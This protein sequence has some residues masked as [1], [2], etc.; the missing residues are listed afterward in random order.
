MNFLRNIFRLKRIIILSL[1][2]YLAHGV[3]L[4]QYYV[5]KISKVTDEKG[6]TPSATYAIVQDQIG[7]IWFGTVDGLYRFD[8]YN[9]KIFR[10]QKNNK[11]SLCNNTIRAVCLGQGGKLWIGTQGG[12]VDC[13]D[14]LTEKFTNYSAKGKSDNE[15]SGNVV[16]S[17]IEDNK[18]N[19]WMGITGKG[20]DMLNTK[21]LQFKHF[22]I[23]IDEKT[24][25]YETTI[26]SLFQDNQG[27]IW[28]ATDSEGLI[29]LDPV[30]EKLKNY[31]HN[32]NDPNSISSNT[33][34]NIYQDKSGKLWIST[35]GKG[36]NLFDYKTET[37]IQIKNKA[38]NPNSL[39]SDLVCELTEKPS[40]GYWISTEYGLSF[41]DE[42]LENIVNYV[43]S[44]CDA[45]SIADNRVRTTFTDKQ[46]I[47]WIGTLTGVDKMIEQN[48]FLSFKNIPSNPNS[49]SGGLVRSILEDNQGNLWIGLIDKGLVRYDKKT[50]IF[51]S[52]K[53]NPNSPNSLSGNHITALFQD[54]NDD[55]WIGEWDT[56][57][58]RYNKTTD[59]CD[60]IINK[61]SG[62]N[63]LSDNRI[64][65]IR[66][67]KPGVLWIGTEG[68][69][70]RFEIKTSKTTYFS[71]NALSANSL[72]SNSVQS[73]A[74]VV[75]SQ[76]NLWVGMWSN[77]L[78][79]IE[80]I[81]STQQKAKFTSWKNDLNNK[82]SLNNDNVISLHLTKSG[83]LW[84]GTF[85]GGL[86]KFDIKSNKFTH[87]A[88]ED[89]L[90]N[91]IIFSI[92][93]DEKGFLWLSTDNGISMFNP[94]TEIFQNFDTNDGLQSD[95]F[96]WGSSFKSKSGELFFGGINGFNS[97]FPESVTVSNFP[98]SPVVLNIKVLDD[99][100]GINYSMSNLKD[101]TLAHAQNFLTFEFAGLD[102]VEPRKNLYK[103]KLEGIDK[104][105]NLVGNRKHATY[106]DLSPGTYY[107]R[108]NVTNSDEVWNSK[109]LVLK[110]TIT[111]PWWKTIFA[112][113]MFALLILGSAFSFYYIRVGMLQS[114]KLKLEEQVALRTNEIL[115]KN[116]D[117]EQKNEEI[118]SQKEVLSFQAE[119]LNE[120]NALLEKAMLELELTQKALFESEKMASLGVLSAGVAHEINNPLN[121]IALSIEIIKSEIAEI[122]SAGIIDEQKNNMLMKLIDHAEV[123]KNRI[124]SIVNDLNLYSNSNGKNMEYCFVDELITNSISEIHSKI[125]TFIQLELNLSEVPKITCDK[126]LIKLVIIGIV[127]NAIHAIHEKPELS[128]EKICI[129]TH[130]INQSGIDFVA[131]DISNTGPAMSPDLISRLFDPFYTT[132]APNKG[133]GLGLYIAYNIIKDHHGFIM[134]ENINS[135]VLFRVLIPI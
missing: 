133:I 125:P 62:I 107:F 98:A 50:G 73:N 48:R 19:I 119:S 12:G 69:I 49:L 65:V 124:S 122:S 28:I 99:I 75:D 37:F 102:F 60:K 67:A 90:P 72:N 59:G 106:T 121:F 57:L 61:F 113:I 17:I 25:S 89:G 56:G 32:P 29:V 45:N 100:I 11:N 20:V 52:Y 77:G 38:N 129:S 87:Y 92:L 36:L 116:S 111:P 115:E 76:G 18:G 43:H 15:I 128:N 108:L 41:M 103:Y 10:H 2:L 14:I 22:N 42:K 1:N 16:R 85:G 33:I 27:K 94:K 26:R 74:L 40:G 131:I 53:H 83:I 7:F 71:H 82:N 93:E 135:M 24:R 68:G 97:C 79:K 86:E 54:S 81:D 3:I 123:G 127:E 39:V 126:E 23:I 58:M 51:H 118:V 47:L 8:G 117:L 101:I 132:K 78:N 110:I 88:L 104:D 80:F 84:I 120:K 34:Y 95:H 63:K 35:Y 9:F 55:I 109:D 105:W 4:G 44:S 21:T 6:L 30:T 66:E 13:F 96:F 91:N 112:K 31:P 134:A 114:Q 130:V 5:P 64:Q 46:G 70:N